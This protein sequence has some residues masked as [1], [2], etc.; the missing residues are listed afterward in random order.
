MGGKSSGDPGLSSDRLFNQSEG[1]RYY[2]LAAREFSRYEYARDREGNF[3]SASP[4]RDN[5][6]IAAVRYAL[7]AAIDRRAAGTVDRKKWGI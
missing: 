5:H 7:E 2:G 1:E 6:T 4:D 3:L